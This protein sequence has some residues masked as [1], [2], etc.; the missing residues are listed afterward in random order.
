M[1]RT[2]A[3][4]W[5]YF[6]W[7]FF[8]FFFKKSKIIWQTQIKVPKV[9]NP[10]LSPGLYF[11]CLHSLP[12]CGVLSLV[13]PS[14]IEMQLHR[15]RVRWLTR[16]FQNIPRPFLQKSPGLLSKFASDL[17]C[18]VLYNGFLS[19]LAKRQ[20]TIHIPVHLRIFPDA[21]VTSSINQKGSRSKINHTRQCQ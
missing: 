5:E 3:L 15:F 11:S 6:I 13:L 17:Q 14:G 10:K 18:E 9:W 1:C 2:W 16:P 21:V 12:A 8:F 7:I 20:Q 19:I 4:K